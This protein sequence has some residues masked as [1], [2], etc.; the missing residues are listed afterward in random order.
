MSEILRRQR[1]AT[2]KR[3]MKYKVTVSRQCEVIAE[4][5][6]QAKERAL[7]SL[8]LSLSGI[9]TVVVPR[10]VF[11]IWLNAAKFEFKVKQL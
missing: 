7:M 1:E 9:E 4:S 3:L 5:E 11:K 10:E 2:G 8:N 6:D